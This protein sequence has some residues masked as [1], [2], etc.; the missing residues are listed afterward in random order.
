MICSPS[1]G[2]ISV[3]GRYRGYCNMICG[4]FFSVLIIA[5]IPRLLLCLLALFP[6]KYGRAAAMSLLVRDDVGANDE[7]RDRD[8]RYRDILY[9]PDDLGMITADSI[10]RYKS[11]QLVALTRSAVLALHTASEPT[12]AKQRLQ[13]LAVF[14]SWQ[15][16]PSFWTAFAAKQSQIIHNQQPEFSR[17][18]RTGYR[19]VDYFGPSFAFKIMDTLV[20]GYGL[21]AMQRRGVLSDARN[22]SDRSVTEEI[23]LRLKGEKLE[24]AYYRKRSLNAPSRFN[25]WG[26][27]L[28]YLF[29]RNLHSFA[30]VERLPF[31]W[32][33]LQLTGDMQSQLSWGVMWQFYHWT[34]AGELRQSTKDY[35]WHR[36]DAALAM[37][38]DYE[39][40][41]LTSLGLM[42]E[43]R[44]YRASLASQFTLTG[45]GLRLGTA[46]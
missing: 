32:Q 26:L 28:R 30:R 38:L 14:G 12:D 1:L 6:F 25:S 17:S 34:M 5:R 42:C 24:W 35:H 10:E 41:S 9:R 29:R 2:K 27:E 36:E 45:C 18:I 33:Q 40:S 46:L 22:A 15:V 37:G 44:Q 39:F 8:I 7:L 31:Q 11:I 43:R 13:H 21:A 16:T 20:L 19:Y 23:A 3:V 4:Q